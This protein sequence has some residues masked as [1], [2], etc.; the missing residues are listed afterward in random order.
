VLSSFEGFDA[1]LKHDS[2]ETPLASTMRIEF[3][4]R[5]LAAALGADK[6][7]LYNWSNS[8][9]F[10][11]WVITS[12]PQGWLPKEF[13]SYESCLLACYQAARKTVTDKLGGDESTWTLGRYF[14][15]RFPHPLAGAPMIGG[16]FAVAPVPQSGGGTTVN[17]AA[18]VSMRLIAD[19]TD[20]D[21]TRQGIALGESG[22]PASPHWKDQ[23]TDWQS[24]NPRNFPFGKRAVAG[25]TKETLVLE[26]RASER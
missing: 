26:P 9:T 10:F 12:R 11:D 18:A 21:N 20:W 23:L 4:R 25:E 14:Q 3:G 15:A 13:D 17:R 19:P 24:A 22:D 1:M 5:I 6:A 16:Q 8:G 7:G 2:R